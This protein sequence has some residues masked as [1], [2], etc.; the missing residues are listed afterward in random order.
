VADVI[1]RL[2]VIYDSQSDDFDGDTV[3]THVEACI[4]ELERIAHSG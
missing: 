4:E 1:E 3:L 2:R